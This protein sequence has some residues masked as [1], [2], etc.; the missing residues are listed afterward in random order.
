MSTPEST[1]ETAQDSATTEEVTL[2]SLEQMAQAAD[3][4]A[5]VIPESKPE[6]PPEPEDESTETEPEGETQIE[7]ESP[8]GA[9]DDGSLTGETEATK[10]SKVE[11]GNVRLDKSWKKHNEEK[12]S[13]ATEKAEFER[14]REEFKR[15]QAQNTDEYKDVDGYTAQDYE[16]AAQNWEEEGEYDRAEWARKQ[17]SKVGTEA[18]QKAQ[19]AQSAVFQE[20]WSA[21]FE[22]AA[23]NNPDLNNRT[24]EL[25]QNVLK[26]IEEKPFLASYPDGI[27][28][29]VEISKMKTQK[30]EVAGLKESL[31]KS[32]EEVEEYKSKLSIGGSPPAGR[33]GDTSFDALSEGDQMKRLENLAAEYDSR[34]QPM[35]GG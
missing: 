28:D 31:K 4:D 13:F 21:N 35:I 30:S 29:A 32:Q 1:V 23:E 20:K 5:G 17:V 2:E 8:V 34:G 9:E 12:E 6:Q 18:Q 19:V 16:R 15:H 27:L 22:K 25:H 3:Q 11:K 33:P 7:T 10:P 14:D 24:S 26:L